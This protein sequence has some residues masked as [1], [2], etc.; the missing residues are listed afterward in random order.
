MFGLAFGALGLML[1]GGADRGI[2]LVLFI[3]FWLAVLAV[4][5]AASGT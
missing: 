4:S 5:Q 1:A 3:P 2:R